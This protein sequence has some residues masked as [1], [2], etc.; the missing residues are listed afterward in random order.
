[1]RLDYQRF[2]MLL[3]LL[4][5]QFACSSEKEDPSSG[6]PSNGLLTSFTNSEGLMLFLYEDGKIYSSDD[7]S[8]TFLVQ[9]F[10]PDFEEENYVTNTSGTFI[11]DDGQLFPTKN[12]FV[13]DFESTTHLNDLFLSSFEDTD[14][15]WTNFTSQSPATP[16]VADYVALNKCILAETCDFIDNRIEL[17]QDPSN[18]SNQ[19]IKFT[20]V[21]PSADMVTSKSSITSS[22]NFFKKGDDIW[23][24]ADY[25]IQSG[26]P[27]SIVDFENSHFTESPGPRIVISNNQIELENKFGD[28]KKY[29]NNTN[30]SIPT[31]QWF[32]LKVHLKLSNEDD[33]IIE[34]WQDENLLVSATGKNVFTANSIQNILEVGT[35]ASSVNTVLLVDNITISAT[36]F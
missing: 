14:G 7:N 17:V 10:D 26:M 6:C 15:Y 9:Y 28:K 3:S 20:N 11:K 18:P 31:N 8:C 16:E 19:V 2:L 33:G 4:A 30:I 23:F 25:N 13:E 5:L 34:V 27:Y 24:Q 32:T 22:L 1:M 35:S 21:A 29:E 12:D 36:A